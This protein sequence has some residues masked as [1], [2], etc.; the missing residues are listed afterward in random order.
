[1]MLID[2]DKII[3]KKIN[4]PEELL[5]RDACDHNNENRKASINP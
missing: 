4:K 3:L 2:K 1:M 5:T